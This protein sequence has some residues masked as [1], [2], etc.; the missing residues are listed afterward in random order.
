M[1]QYIIEFIGFQLVFLIVYDIFLRKETFF[2]WNRVY[3]LGT[4]ILSLFLP[5]LKIE[6]LTTEV[7]VEYYVYPEFLWNDQVA[8]IEIATNETT[9]IQLSW[10][11]SVF[12]IGVVAAFL[13]FIYK[14]SKLYLLRKNGQVQYFTEFTQIIVSN[15]NL[16]FSFF[17]SIFLGDQVVKEEHDKIIQHELIHIKQKHSI[18]LL[19]FEMLRILCWFNPLVYVYQGRVSELHEFIADARVAKSNKKEQ[20]QLL[21]SQVFQTQHISF[22]NQFFR[23]SLI[24]KRIVMLQ[25]SKSKKIWQLKYILLIPLITGMLLYTSC[26]QE[27]KESNNSTEDSLAER[28]ASLQKEIE[29]KE[30]LTQEE[31]SAI[32]KMIYE[33]FPKNVEGISGAKG[34]LSHTTFN[35]V[36]SAEGKYQQ[37]AY[38]RGR[39]LKS[40]NEQNPIIV[41]IDQQLE[42]I[43]GYIL[44]NNN[45]T[46]PF[47]WT[48][49]PPIFPGCEGASN[50][51]ECFQSS[52]QKHISENFKYP[53]EAQEKGLQGRVNV[54]FTIDKE[55]NVIDFRKRGPDK[56]LEDEAERIIMKLPKMKPG[57]Y[58]GES[59][60]VPF[61]VPIS[62]KL[63]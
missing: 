48:D 50:K 11:E 28:I 58:K 43:K 27:G 19:F 2:Q 6:A 54:M 42:A 45:G 7:P 53:Q 15:S 34:W 13:L 8:P 40:A 62:F 4:H 63:Q 60:S 37:L 52:M 56:L 31:E 49:E 29:E 22:I 35:D 33:V 32:A 39:L 36:K 24:K 12:I 23:S 30:D 44:D 51:S 26:E 21:L 47:G 14:I 46:I 38:E 9:W 20:Y 17:K 41:N 5:W 18:D 1:I 3:L 55:G 25:K 59:V 10:Q 57:K 16:A 61:S